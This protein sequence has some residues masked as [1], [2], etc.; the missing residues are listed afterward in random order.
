MLNHMTNWT[1]NKKKHK[2]TKNKKQKQNYHEAQITQAH[3][4]NRGKRYLSKTLTIKWHFCNRVY[5]WDKA[6]G[7][8]G[9]FLNDK[10]TK[11]NNVKRG[12]LGQNGISIYIYIYI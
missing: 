12:L 4:P 8:G 7:T 9:I 6:S 11:K 10:I 2:K 5:A 1:T 3:R